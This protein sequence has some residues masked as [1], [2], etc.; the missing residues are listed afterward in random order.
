M[1]TLTEPP[2]SSP[3]P[4]LLCLGAARTGTA[5]LMKALRILG[6]SSVHHGWEAC[7]SDNLQWQCPTFDRANDATFPNLSTYRGTPF[8]RAEWDEL[9]GEYDAVS[10]I[11]SHYAESLIPAYPDAKV[12]LVERDIETW[13]KSVV[14]VVQ[15]SESPR[16]RA[17]VT[18]LS[19]FTGY[20]SGPVCF[21]MQQGWPRSDS[22]NDVL[23]YLKPAYARH[24]KY[25]RGA[26]PSEQLLEF[27]LSDGWEPLCRFL[28]KEVPNVPFPHV[29]DS[30]EYKARRRRLGNKIMKVAARKFFCPYLRKRV[31][32]TR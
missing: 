18:K 20:A 21:R 24:N 29:N 32:D 2:K 27:K 4:P 10:D 11:A 5:S 23:K 1:T 9:F 25:V 12:I 31:V 16:Y 15:A 6:Y 28:G 13:Y 3:T 14:P 19:N 22:S 26:V 7:E 30:A 8:S 17:F